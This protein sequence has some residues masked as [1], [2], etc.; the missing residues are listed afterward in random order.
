[1]AR[2]PAAGIMP[3]MSD[4][5]PPTLAPAAPPSVPA[6][7]EA[8]DL[9]CPFCGYNLRGTPETTRCPECGIARDPAAL[10]RSTIPWEARQTIGRFRA[11]WK[12]AWLV[13]RHPGRLAWNVNAPLSYGDAQKFR[14]I[15]VALVWVT[16]TATLAIAYAGRE[17]ESGRLLAAAGLGSPYPEPIIGDV[18]DYVVLAVASG[19]FF[20]FITGVHTYWFEPRRLTPTQRMR[21]LTLATYATGILAWLPLL[22]VL[23]LPLV[24]LHFVHPRLIDPSR[25]NFAVMAS[26]QIA[27]AVPLL[28]GLLIPVRYYV[29][30]LQLLRRTTHGGTGRTWAAACLLP[31]TWS[32]VALLTLLLIPLLAFFGV[33]IVSSL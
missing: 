11:F 1:L 13:T 25:A 31:L 3:F 7:P 26:I 10:R 14:W 6:A 32:V 21:A 18:L 8:A 23:G 12:T 2:V 22:L 17:T 29:A 15:V 5:A 16:V 20:L 4:D 27:T 19:L 24:D 9:F 30:I 28:L 33:V